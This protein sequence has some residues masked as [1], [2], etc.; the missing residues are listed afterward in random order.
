MTRAM[1]V[2][3]HG[4]RDADG[5]DEF[6]ALASTIRAAAGELLTGFGFIELASPS[7]DEAIDDLVVRGATEIVSVPLV[8]LAAG[9][10][11]NDGPAALARARTR[12]PEVRFH[13]ARDLGIDPLVLEVATDR[14]REAAGDADPEKLGVALIGRGCSDPDACADLWKVSRLLSDGRGLGTVEPGFVSIA[15]PGIAETLERLR[16]LGAGTTVLA[17]F[18]L[19]PGVLLNRIYA[20]AASWAQDHP[21]VEVRGASHLGPDP[22]LARLALERYREARAGDVRMNCDLCTYRVQLPGY[23]AKVGTP[24]SLT[25]HGDGP[26]VGSRRA[27]RATRAPTPAPQIRRGRFIGSQPVGEHPAIEVRD[28]DFA[29]PD[30]RQA[31]SGVSMRVEA[32][33]RVA[34]LGPNGAGK[35]SLVLQLNGVLTPSAGSVTIG[36]IQVGRRT[37]AEVRRRVGVV[38]QDPDDQLFTP[39]VGR[40]VAFGPAHLGLSGDTLTARVAEA[41][42]YV[43]LMDAADR[44]PHRL[45]LGERRRAAV[46]TVLAMHPEVLV[47]DEPTAN[48]DPAARREFAD[49]I[50]R[51]GM[52]TLLVTHDL[53]YALELCPRALV[54]DHGQIV[55]DGP[56]RE[57]LAD[58]GFMSAHRLELPAGFNPLGA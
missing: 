8:L 33:E 12:H 23:E 39:T 28:L 3:G 1:L 55:A 56:T 41:L 21:E 4:S 37:L 53:P 47:L 31:L 48:L 13:L 34:L 36:G 51:L 35:T 46:A 43:G 49:L 40:D 42:S 27:R 11:K 54:I 5:V 18:F 6:W 20:E 15:T 30:G 24:I 22:R 19:F 45:S 26:A 44:P 50:K 10:L 57:V 7:V 52:T 58:T 16:L 2:V 25:P 29:Y 14:I 38:F 9:H 32:G 17:P